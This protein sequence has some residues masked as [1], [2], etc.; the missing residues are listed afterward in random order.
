MSSPPRLELVLAVAAGV[1]LLAA[2]GGKG[3]AAR[4]P[5][6]TRPPDQTPAASRPMLAPTY[7]QVTIDAA[8]SLNLEVSAYWKGSDLIIAEGSVDLPGPAQLQAWICQDG[9]YAVA[10]RLKGTP[11]IKN[12]QVKAEWE[13]VDVDVGPVFDPGARFEAVL[14]A[15]SEMGIPFFVVRI[16]V[17]GR[18]E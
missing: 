4:E 5:E 15:Q 3:D 14:A 2:C 7:C 1:V 11:E 12:G 13:L 9:Q 10:L 16:P 18:P 6:S 17:E 8:P